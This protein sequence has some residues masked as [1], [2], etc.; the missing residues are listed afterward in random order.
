MD[1]NAVRAVLRVRTLAPHGISETQTEIIERLRTLRED[2]AIIELDIDVW[3]PSM[4]VAHPND[5]SQS[6]EHDRV[7]EF[8]RWAREHG[9]T[10][11]PAFDRRESGSLV[12]Q[13]ATE[14]IIRL[15]L[16]C[17]GVYEG[18]TI[19]AVYPH[20]DGETVYTIHDGVEAL[21]LMR[22][23][24]ADP[25]GEPIQTAEQASV[26]QAVIEAEE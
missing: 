7:A 1:S 3:G 14:Q 12:D 15:P 10:L 17:L 6:I 21:E 22:E 16:L 13:G 8:E 20:V 18:S 9:C 4:R 25:V 24:S 11:Q 23:R 5:R 26:E 19:R 2:G